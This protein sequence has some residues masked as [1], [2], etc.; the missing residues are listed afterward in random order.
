MATLG[1][2]IAILFAIDQDRIPTLVA[3]SL[4]ILLLF[5]GLAGML[6]FMVLFLSNSATLG[7]AR[8]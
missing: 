8:R 7:K 6:L 2:A 3:K 1:I 4:M 5:L